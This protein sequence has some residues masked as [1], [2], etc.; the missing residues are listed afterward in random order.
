MLTLMHDMPDM[1]RGLFVEGVEAEIS[2][3]VAHSIFPLSVIDQQL[4]GY[5]TKFATLRRCGRRRQHARD[6]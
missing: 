4:P 1:L 5:A 6:L 3:L 2:I